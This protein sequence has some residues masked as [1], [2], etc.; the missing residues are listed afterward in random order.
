LVKKYMA[1]YI[2]T[3]NQSVCSVKNFTMHL[4]TSCCINDLNARV[5]FGG[6]GYEK[7]IDIADSQCRF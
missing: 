2:L 5:N 1:N 3:W 7:E 4:H 6:D